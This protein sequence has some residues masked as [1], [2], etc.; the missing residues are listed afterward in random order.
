MK[1]TFSQLDN[2]IQEFISGFVAREIYLKEKKHVDTCD[3]LLIFDLYDVDVEVSEDL[4]IQIQRN[5]KLDVAVKQI[6]AQ[7]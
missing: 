3:L 6:V 7:F 5:H 1:T 4:T 2:D